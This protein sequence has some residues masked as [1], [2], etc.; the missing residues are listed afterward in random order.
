MICEFAKKTLSFMRKLHIQEESIMKYTGMSYVIIT[1]IS[2]LCR[3]LHKTDIKIIEIVP[4]KGIANEDVVK[5]K[6]F[7]LED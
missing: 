2:E 3:W 7:H 6:Y 4:T 1:S 5:L